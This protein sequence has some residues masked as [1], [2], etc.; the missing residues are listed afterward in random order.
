MPSGTAEFFCYNNVMNQEY[1]YG[2]VVYRRDK[3]KLVVLIEYMKLGHISLP[4]GHIE[5]GETPVQCAIREIKEET[6]LDVDIDTSFERKIVY[7]PAQNISK[8]V[9]FYLAKP[10][11]LIL[12]P[13]LAE[14][15]ALKWLEPK[16]A[17]EALS[18]ESDKKVLTDAVQAILAKAD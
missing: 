18:F 3:G 2:A 9:T 1:S 12:K 16:A 17:L 10:K 11:T 15:F 8:T 4:K 7:S 14:V 13:Q 5:K 6:N